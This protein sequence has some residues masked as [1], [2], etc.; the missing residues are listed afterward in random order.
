MA[1]WGEVQPAFI[2]RFSEIRSEGQVA[3][4]LK[5]EYIEDYYDIFLKLCMVIP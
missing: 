1:T 2:N 5:Y 3:T 4:T